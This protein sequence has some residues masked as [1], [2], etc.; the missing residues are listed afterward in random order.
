MSITAREPRPLLKAAASTREVLSPRNV[1]R[2]GQISHSSKD[3][4]LDLYVKAPNFLILTVSLLLLFKNLSLVYRPHAW[5][6]MAVV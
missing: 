5:G 3:R 1:S 2:Y 6:E 4:N